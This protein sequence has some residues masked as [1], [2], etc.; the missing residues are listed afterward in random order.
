MTV[1]AVLVV[2]LARALADELGLARDRNPER[3]SARAT[4]QRT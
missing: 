3:D 4:E 1:I 2:T